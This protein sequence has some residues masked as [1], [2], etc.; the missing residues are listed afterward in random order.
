M[1]FN[2]ENPASETG[3]GIFCGKI[4][5]LPGGARAG[6]VLVLQGG[7]HGDRDHAVVAGEDLLGA[8]R[9]GLP[10]DQGYDRDEDEAYEHGQHTGPHFFYR[11]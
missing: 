2:D 3:N 8:G 10:C 7:T 9:L 1:Q 4:R 6:S 5:V 11:K